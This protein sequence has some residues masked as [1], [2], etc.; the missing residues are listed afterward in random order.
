[1]RTKTSR[2]I[3]ITTFF[4]C[5]SV[6]AQVPRT[7]NYQGKLTNPSGIAVSGDYNID[8][9]IYPAETGGSYSWHQT[10]TVTITNGLFE[11]QL[12]LSI[13]G[14]DTLSFARPYWL[15]LQIASDPEMT[16][17]EKLAPV[18]FAYRAVY[19]DTT[20][21]VSGGMPE[22][23]ENQ[24]IRRN[25]SDWE[26]TNSIVIESDGDVGIGTTTPVAKLDVVGNI[27]VNENGF[28]FTDPENSDALIGLRASDPIYSD[29]GISIRTGAD[30][31]AGEPIF[32]V[33]SSGGSER[34]RVEHNGA[35]RTSNTSK[36]TEW[37]IATL[38][39]I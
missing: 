5:A 25:A 2:F 36:L 31:P 24:T 1:M 17:R 29:E 15:A 18:A 26:A 37:G 4:V 9:R 30:S 39:E 38:L 35:L 14:G 8:F 10:K 23:T 22:G 3:V 21:Y 11:E 16:P 6:F 19:S 13:N 28:L 20:S 27:Q 32:R 34:L 12:D 7:M 33:I